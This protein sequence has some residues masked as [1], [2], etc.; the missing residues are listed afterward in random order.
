MV[1]QALRHV[2][3]LWGAAFFEGQDKKGSRGK[4]R[5]LIDKLQSA[6]CKLTYVVVVQ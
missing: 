3:I 6:P 1:V 4:K 5:G 2:V